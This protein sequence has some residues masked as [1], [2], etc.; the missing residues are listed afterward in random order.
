MALAIIFSVL[1]LAFLWLTS[2]ALV[3]FAVRIGVKLGISTLVIGVIF[4]G[5]GTS[6]PEL[7]V[8]A[9]SAG[10][11]L[12]LAV[13]NI[14]GSNASNLSLVLGGSILVAGALGLKSRGVKYLAL[15]SIVSCGIFAW[16][17]QGEFSLYEG[18]ILLVLM[19]P[20]LWLLY[21]V[22]KIQIGGDVIADE[23]AEEIEAEHSWMGK[24]VGYIVGPNQH[25]FKAESLG[26]MIVGGLVSLA[27]T[28]G[29]A[30]L[31]VSGVK[32]LA[33]EVGIQTGFLGLTLVAVGTSAPE[34]VV[35]I[36]SARRG[37]I[38]LLTGNLLG[39]NVLNSLF[40]GGVIGILGSG[41]VA[42]GR[43]TTIITPMSLG[44]IV[45]GGLFI[46]FSSK[47]TRWHAIVLVVA[48]AAMLGFSAFGAGA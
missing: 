15:I 38:D 33:D 34:I 35:G 10:K 24:V 4:V 26:R 48:W 3:E 42:D 1:G 19:G 27:G 23:V 14:V 31:L 28:V 17:V 21:Y 44:V 7:T 22:N 40:V 6:L 43:L 8:S 45:L 16:F 47:I 9:L 41:T 13:S 25:G 37:Q 36:Q 2:E 5:F 29:S 20:A 32:R 12:P 11:D 18:I 30:Q 39:S 46:V